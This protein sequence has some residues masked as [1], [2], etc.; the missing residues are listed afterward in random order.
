MSSTELS[1]VSKLL[2][3]AVDAMGGDLGASVVVE[4]AV[5]A[6]REFGINSI[7]VGAETEIRSALTNL[8]ASSLEGLQ[9]RHAPDVVTMEDSPTVA[10]RKKPNASI[11]IAFELVKEGKACAVVSPGN[12][13]A[14]MAAGIYVSGTLPGIVRPAIASLIP[15]V[16]NCVPGVLLDSGAN[17]DC[18]AHQLVQFALMGNYYAMSALRKEKP[19]VALL[20]NG[21]EL[22]KGT[23]I[24]RSAALMLADYNGINFIGFVE[25]RDLARDVVDVIVCDGFV[26]NIVLKTVEGSVEF[27]LDSMRQQIGKS[28]A[29]KVGMWLAKPSLKG[30]FHD[31]L[32]PSSYG[33]APLLGLNDAAIVCHGSSNAKAIM[34]GI[35]VARGFY[36]DG[37]ISKICS[38]LNVLDLKM[39]GVIEDGM[40][41][42]MRQ[43]FEKKKAG[44]TGNSEPVVENTSEQDKTS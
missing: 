14:V 42:R 32:D 38:A 41:G 43:R 18:H 28:I 15:K 29:G 16:G 6:L 23:D 25:G 31:K 27:V 24:L 44:G 5:L 2:P 8:G 37:V 20:S 3:V 26:G 35:R 10:L 33:G 11:R 9:V 17:I 34:N 7:L 19:R 30:L 12:T 36:D 4:G 22:S 39:P 13:G 40:W 21:A 1:Q